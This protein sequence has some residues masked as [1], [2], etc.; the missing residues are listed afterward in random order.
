MNQQTI[1]VLHVV[2]G[3][4]RGGIETFLM[5]VLRRR[6]RQ[7][8]QMD[9]VVH[10]NGAGAYDDDVRGLGSRIFRCPFTSRPPQYSRELRRILRTRGPFDVVHSHVHHYDGHVL[11][12][13]RGAGV[14]VRVSHS[15]NDTSHFDDRAGFARRLYLSQMKR[16]IQ[17]HATMGFACSRLAADSLFGAGWENDSRWKLLPYGIDLRPFH[18][19]AD[20]DAMRRELGIPSDALF[21]IH[22]GRFDPQKNHGFLIQTAAEIAKRNSNFRLLLL[23]KGS[24]Q[25]GIEQQVQELGLQ[26]Q[27]IF[28]G[29]RPDVPC[30]L[31]AADVFLMPSLHEGLPLAGIEAQA[32]GLPAI[33]ADTVTPEI[34]LV[35]EMV[36]FLSLEK[37]PAEWAEA[38]LK[39]GSTP[40]PVAREKALATVENS[41][42]NIEASVARLENFY[43]DAFAATTASPIKLSVA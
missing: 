16:A 40:R 30:C 19:P 6:N 4:D 39:A 17:R 41:L 42:C 1:R 11:N 21:A 5:H 31:M 15:H 22:I 3:L 9:F 20:R 13:A 28:A 23:G 34:A 2:G 14:P 12:I 38:A 26:E 37:T 43:D 29:S 7:R 24:L 27:I 8:L 10:Q 32:A 35:P 18:E 25:P 36:Q 33:I